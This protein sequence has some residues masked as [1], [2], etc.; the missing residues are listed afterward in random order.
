MVI[1][2]LI[3]EFYEERADKNLAYI[4]HLVRDTGEMNRIRERFSGD[5]E[6]EELV[7]HSV[8]LENQISQ[9]LMEEI[10][11]DQRAIREHEKR[12]TFESAAGV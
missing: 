2:D 7:R 5:W 11:R 1:P 9:S 3:T 8:F 10:E 12:R 4:R 6:L